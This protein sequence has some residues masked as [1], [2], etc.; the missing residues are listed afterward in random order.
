MSGRARM[1]NRRVFIPVVLGA[2]SGRAYAQWAAR[3]GARY[4]LYCTI[5]F[6]VMWTGLWL[7]A[8]TIAAIYLAD[9][10]LLHGAH[11]VGEVLELDA[12]PYTPRHTTRMEYVTAVTY[13]FTAPDG[14]R[15]TN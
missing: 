8:G 9:R 7:A 12:K 14:R 13:A 15:F 5:G 2:F 6:S 3:Y 11:I 4:M 1:T 10:S